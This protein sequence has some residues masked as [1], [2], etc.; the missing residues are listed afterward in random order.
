MSKAKVIQAI[1]K[2]EIGVKNS[3]GRYSETGRLD[4][5]VLLA[6]WK[7]SLTRY[8]VDDF[9][10]I[11]RGSLRGLYADAATDVMGEVFQQL[12]IEDFDQL[13]ALLKA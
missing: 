12:G 9:R 3:D 10:N 1:Q 11:Y 5:L 2:V 7:D 8:G 4:R 6:E 13:L